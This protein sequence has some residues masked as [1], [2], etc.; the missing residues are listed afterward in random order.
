MPK[1]PAETLPATEAHN[2]ESV[3][4]SP[5]PGFCIQA[6]CVVLVQELRKGGRK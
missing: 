4:V 1:M 2:P 6:G 3:A 5:F